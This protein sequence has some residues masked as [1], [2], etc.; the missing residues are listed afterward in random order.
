MTILLSFW[1]IIPVRFPIR[2]AV[3]SAL[4]SLTV[5][6]YVWNTF[7]LY[8]RYTTGELVEYWKFCATPEAGFITALAGKSITG[9]TADKSVPAGTRTVIVPRS[10][11]RRV[12]KEGRE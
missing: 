7:P 5:T 6:R 8:T 2:K 3:I 10:E 11:E 12:G 4:I 1:L 9:A